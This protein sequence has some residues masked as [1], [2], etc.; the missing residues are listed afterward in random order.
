[1]TERFEVRNRETYVINES[2]YRDDGT[3]IEDRYTV[4]EFVPRSAGVLTRSLG[5]RKID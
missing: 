3:D 2:T 5:E 4:I 1:M